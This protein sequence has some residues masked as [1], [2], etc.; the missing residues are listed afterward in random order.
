MFGEG[1]GC[2]RT[3]FRLLVADAVGE[4][5]CVILSETVPHWVYDVIVKVGVSFLFGQAEFPVIEDIG[6]Q[7][8]FSGSAIFFR[9][10]CSY[11]FKNNQELKRRFT[12]RDKF[13]SCLGDRCHAIV[14]PL[15]MHKFN[16]FQ[17]R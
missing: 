7:S 13:L 9:F 4:N 3:F 15:L 14:T 10:L 12:L 1:G 8:F 2:G 16:I 6:K 11:V 5:E 17:S